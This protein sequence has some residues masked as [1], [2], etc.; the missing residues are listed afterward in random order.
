MNTKLSPNTD[1]QKCPEKRQTPEQARVSGCRTQKVESKKQ[2]GANA[3]ERRES[4]NQIEPAGSKM[5][6][7]REVQS[8][9]GKWGG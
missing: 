8:P 7:Q 3:E 1:L 5:C 4:K 6:G 2:T 9:S